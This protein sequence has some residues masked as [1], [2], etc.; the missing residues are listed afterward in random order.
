MA[1]LK[2][3]AITGTTNYLLFSNSKHNRGIDISKHRKLWVSME[4]YGFLRCFP[5]VCV[6]KNG[7]LIVKDGQHRLQIAQDLGLPVFYVVEETDFDIA[8]I[9]NTPKTWGLYDYA[10]N[11]ADNGRKA[12]REGLKFAAHHRLPIGVAFGMLYGTTSKNV[13]PC[14][15]SGTFRIKDRAW[16]DIVASTYTAMIRLS[17]QLKTVRFLEALMAACRVKGFVP[18][19]LIRGAQRCLDRL[20]S[21][22]TRDAYLEMM[23]GLYNFNRQKTVPLKFMAIRAMKLR[24]PVK[25]AKK[26]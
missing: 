19:R 3:R 16:A 9:N 1:R 13:T 7:K 17:K 14:L 23:E 24:N 20:G 25:K 5:I 10:K 12:Y 8:E 21:Y 4:K 2:S 18:S 15:R 11:Y 6:R 22:S 26:K